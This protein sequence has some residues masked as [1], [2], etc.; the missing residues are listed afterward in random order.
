MQISITTNGKRSFIWSAGLVFLGAI[1]FSTKAILVK[2]AY[3]WG[4]DSVSLLA[5]R[6]LFSL[7]FFLLV[8]A[9]SGRQEKYKGLRLGR[10]D[11][12]SL[13]LLGI[14]G[15]YLASLLDFMGLQYITASL[16]RL[17]LYVYP[18][19]VLIIGALFYRQPITRV[20]LLALLCSYLGIGAAFAESFSLAGSA[21]IAVGAA[22]VFGSALSYA[23]YLVGSGQLLPRL[24]TLRFTS[25][26]MT[27]ACLAVLAHHG[28][29]YHWRL[30]HFPMAVYGLALLMA[31][32]ATVIPSFLISEGIRAIG[33]GNASIVGSIGP[34]STIV[35]AYFFLGEK[36]GWLQWLGTA[37]VIVGVLLTTLSKR[38]SGQN[39]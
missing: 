8:A 31:V 12:V 37:L 10:K 20:Q 36:L 33:S 22:L 39:R 27:T 1:L 7:P 38:P 11:L 9:L 5:L 6:M 23:I 24:G 2:L 29:L 25:L 18:T 17:I 30:F 13:L 21:H 19:L 34:I 16:E 4:I 26:A 3:R 14:A 28:I 32:A 35:L 15:Y